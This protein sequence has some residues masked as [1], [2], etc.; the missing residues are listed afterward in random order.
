M[1]CRKMPGE[2]NATATLGSNL[3][4]RA[5]IPR[6]HVQEP[7]HPGDPADR[8]Y[9]GY[10]RT[11][12]GCSRRYRV[13]KLHA[14]QHP[15]AERIPLRIIDRQSAKARPARSGYGFRETAGYDLRAGPDL[16]RELNTRNL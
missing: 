11:I 8:G 4:Q 13:E 1:R 2:S 14:A 12:P 7:D 10:Q 5:E 16:S 3:C 6:Q 15:M 9:K